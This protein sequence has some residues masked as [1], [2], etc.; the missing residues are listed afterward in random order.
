MLLPVERQALGHTGFKETGVGADP[1]VNLVYIFLSNRVNPS[2]NSPGLS[3]LN[4]RPKIQ[5]V[6]Y[7]AIN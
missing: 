1:K 7:S 3:R 5:E 2:R 4:V 6:I